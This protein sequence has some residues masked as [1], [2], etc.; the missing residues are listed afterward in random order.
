[1]VRKEGLSRGFGFITFSDEMSV[2][3]CLVVEHY[4]NG[5]KV[6]SSS[7]A[8]PAPPR[9]AAEGAHRA[10]PVKPP[11]RRSTPAPATTHPVPPP[12]LILRPHPTRRPPWAQVELK[13]AVPKEEMALRQGGGYF[14]PPPHGMYGP[15]MHMMA[16][17]PGAGAGGGGMAGRGRGEGRNGRE[18]K[19]GGAA[20]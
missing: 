10:A 17:M 2:E 9:V 16:P 8:A 13:R 4:I 12:A 6:G 18:V 7:A 5:R 14:Y 15:P 20:V 3:K 1:M 11:P 19:G